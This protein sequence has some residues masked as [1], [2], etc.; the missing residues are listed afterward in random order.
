MIDDVI[1]AER[2][3]YHKHCLYCRIDGSYD[4]GPSCHGHIGILAHDD[5]ISQ[6]VADSHI[7]VKGHHAQEHTLC[8]PHGQAKEHLHCTARKGNGLSF[9]KE[10]HQGGGNRGGGVVDVQEGEV[11]QKEVRRGVKV[12][13]QD[14]DYNEST[15][16]QK[17]TTYIMKVSTNKSNLSLG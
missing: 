13:V 9:W 8:C 12:R 3:L 11:P 6:R 17:M 5:G 4:L 15:I 16:S 1:P 7:A 2:Q 14:V 10:A